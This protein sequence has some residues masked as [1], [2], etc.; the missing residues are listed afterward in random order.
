MESK[1]SS[2]NQKTKELEDSN[3]EHLLFL[4]VLSWTSAQQILTEVGVA[5]D[6][7]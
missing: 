7:L 1:N 2:N 6:T 3:H 4:G 5:S